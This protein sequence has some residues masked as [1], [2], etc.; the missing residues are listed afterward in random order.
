M[1]LVRMVQLFLGSSYCLIL[2]SNG[3]SINN[4]VTW[5]LIFGFNGFIALGIYIIERNKK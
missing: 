3:Y 2:A 5:V 4:P 1:I